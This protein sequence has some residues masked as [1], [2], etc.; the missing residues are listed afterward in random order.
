MQRRPPSPPSPTSLSDGYADREDDADDPRLV[1][2]AGTHSRLRRR[3]AVVVHVR[4][5]E[6]PDTAPETSALWCGAARD[7]TPEE[8]GDWWDA[9]RPAAVPFLPLPLDP[10]LPL[11][12][13]RAPPPKSSGCGA[14]VHTSAHPALTGR[15]WV[16]WCA[17]VDLKTVVPL[18][19]QYFAEPQ[20]RA[21]EL[22]R[23]RCGCK[24]EGVG[25]AVCG[26]ALGARQAP[27]P[28]HT[29][30]VHVPRKSAPHYIFLPEAVSP[31][32]PIPLPEPAIEAGAEGPAPHAY[33]LHDVPLPPVDTP[34]TH[35]EVDAEAQHV[36]PMP[37]A[38]PLRERTRAR[39]TLQEAHLRA[40]RAAHPQTP[41]EDDHEHENEDPYVRLP[42]PLP[43]SE[44][45]EVAMDVDVADAPGPDPDP[46]AR[47]EEGMGAE[48]DG[49][50]EHEHD[51]TLDGEATRALRAHVASVLAERRAQ[52]RARPPERAQ[53]RSPSPP[54]TQP[55][56]PDPE[57]VPRARTRMRLFDR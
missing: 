42:L 47:P 1:L 14:R 19:T 28:T 10:A 3:P 49:A 33:L 40:L 31:P 48:G 11:P 41:H 13:P 38:P 52:T 7:V 29:I 12:V 57:R 53:T 26:N 43:L 15:F 25:C 55:C 37:A 6:A 22:G 23:R 9:R 27:C 21:L 34:S 45:E 44:G 24:A 4:A 16:G 17:G 36:M 20:R 8:E 46:S 18:E 54:Q 35:I 5:L 56:P 51:R 39:R 2:A 30:A 32:I 50:H